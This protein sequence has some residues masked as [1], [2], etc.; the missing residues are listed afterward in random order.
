MFC[1][2]CGS[3]YAPGAALCPSCGAP[4]LQP[5][6]ETKPRDLVVSQEGVPVARQTEPFA[7][8][9]LATGI[10]SFLVLPVLGGLMAVI[11]GHLA[12]G[13]IRRSSGT[14][15]GSGVALAGLLLGYLNLGLFLLLIATVIF[16]IGGIVLGI[17]NGG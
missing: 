9:S 6:R 3:K 14:R 13:S 8:A 16:G 17:L 10:A 15:E 12:R 11:L 2:S 5:P 1:Q 4:T 7:I